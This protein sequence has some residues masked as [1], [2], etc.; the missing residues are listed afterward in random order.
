MSASAGRALTGRTAPLNVGFVGNT[1]NYP[2]MLARA[3]RA[4][5]HGVT[6]YIDSDSPLHRPERR[7]DDV[8]LPYPDWI[9]DVSALR[10]RD[11]LTPTRAGRAIRKLWRRHDLLVV[12]GMGPAMTVSMPAPSFAVLTGSDLEYVASWHSVGLEFKRARRAG[13]VVEGLAAALVQS[14]IVARQRRALRRCRG[15]NYFA[16]GLVE[17]ADRMLDSLG[18]DEG[19]RTAFML[20]GVDS[21][22]PA[23]AAVSED[24][25]VRIFNVARLTWRLPV[26]AHLCALDM[27]GTDVLLE[28]VAAFVAQ[29]GPC[30]RLVLVRKGE[31][32]AATQ[33]LVQSLGLD[34]VVEWLGEMTQKDVLH[35]Y[36]QAHIVADQLSI[37]VVGMGGLDAMATGR[38]VIANARPEVFEPLIGKPTEIFHARTSQDVLRHLLAL[39][40]DPALR[41]AAGQRSRRYVEKYF[42]PEHGARQILATVG[43]GE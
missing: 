39:V 35:Q 21:I 4:L 19:R 6:V 33:E 1:N 14:A 26:P 23:T 36:R 25:V 11:W 42:S 30:V 5:G 2:F 37:S 13:G 34:D 12:N 8:S 22:A 41:A 9:V 24:G 29:R 40:P 27:K 43:W 31:D 28:G 32:V 20:S 7:Y 18:I 38:P 3:L 10:M 17:H 16:R 15:V